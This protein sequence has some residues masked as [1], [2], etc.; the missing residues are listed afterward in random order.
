MENKYKVGDIVTLREWEPQERER[1]LDSSGDIK[2]STGKDFLIKLM[3]QYCGRRA[4][5]I[6]S[7][8]RS[9]TLDI[10]N[11]NY[12]WTE[13]MIAHNFTYGEEIE[14]RCGGDT[15]WIKRKFVGFIDGVAN[16]YYCVTE[17]FKEKFTEGFTYHASNWA[18]ARKI[19]QKTEK[20]LWLEQGLKKGFIDIQGVVCT[21]KYLNWLLNKI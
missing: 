1:G 18:L 8:D 6:K 12:F 19:V 21:K 17:T 7:F 14:V 20:E 3:K 15:D 5:I 10:D 11:G 4:T 16:P 9:Y 13:E 2:S